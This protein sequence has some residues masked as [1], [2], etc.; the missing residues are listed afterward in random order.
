MKNQSLSSLIP[1]LL[2]LFSGFSVLA[3]E[4]PREAFQTM[5]SA[6]ALRYS[7]DAGYL[8]TRLNQ[9]EERVHRCTI[10]KS[11]KREC[12]KFQ[13]ESIAGLKSLREELASKKRT[14]V[15][16]GNELID[17]LDQAQSQVIQK[18][19]GASELSLQKAKTFIK[20]AFMFGIGKEAENV[21]TER[22]VFLMH[23]NSTWEWPNEGF[24]RLIGVIQAYHDGSLQAFGEF[25]PEHAYSQRALRITKLL[26]QNSSFQLQEVHVIKTPLVNAYV[27]GGNVYL[28]QG[29]MDYYQNDGDLGLVLGHEMGHILLSHNKKKVAGQ[30]VTGAG[31][32]AVATLTAYGI[33]G[34]LLNGLRGLLGKEPIFEENP[35]GRFNDRLMSKRSI[36]YEL[37]ADSFGLVLAKQTFPDWYPGRSVA[38]FRRLYDLI[39]L[40]KLFNPATAL[41][42]QEI[43][44][45]YRTHPH[46]EDREKNCARVTEEL[47]RKNGN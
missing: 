41:L 6:E 16:Y 20:E 10:R 18:K 23:Y 40:G 13:K 24:E 38:V 35:A 29:I 26:A 46:L 34:K 30:V 19:Y 44:L 11:Q 12:G 2:V 14:V 7:A 4:D 43:K 5:T 47:E 45:S 25:N 33:P 15:A 28:T 1:A 36:K 32:L 42:H 39:P 17:T 3:G 21:W 8:T 22:K 9:L 31:S 27:L 37:E